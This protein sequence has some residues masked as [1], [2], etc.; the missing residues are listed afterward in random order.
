MQS[1]NESSFKVPHHTELVMALTDYLKQISYKI[2]HLIEPNTLFLTQPQKK[3]RYAPDLIAKSPDGKIA[4]GLAVN[5]IK[6]Y[7]EPTKTK[8]LDFACRYDRQS[9]LPVEFFIGIPDNNDAFY[10]I[11]H[12][13]AD[14]KSDRQKYN[15]RI[16]RLKIGNTQPT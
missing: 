10:N 9:K 8:L 11:K 2:T 16:I 3:G 6:P 15:V 12:F 1:D 4:I 7:N 13:Y 5:I 14:Q